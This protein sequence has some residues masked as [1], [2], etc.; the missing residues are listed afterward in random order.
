MIDDRWNNSTKCD[1]ECY[2]NE[3]RWHC[4]GNPLIARH[5]FIRW[6]LKCANSPYISHF[7]YSNTKVNCLPQL[8]VF[9]Q[10]VGCL[11]PFW[12]FHSNPLKNHVK[13]SVSRCSVPCPILCLP[14][15][16]M[17]IDILAS[18]YEY[19]NRLNALERH[20]HLMFPHIPHSYEQVLFFS[21]FN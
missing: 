8:I 1:T 5:S 9:F 21:L 17:H 14:R 20:D 15:E 13:T 6:P 16:F 3:I 11:K 2:D 10:M 19:V 4:H 7:L 12:M 18:F